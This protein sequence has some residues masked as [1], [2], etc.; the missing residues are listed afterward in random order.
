MFKILAMKQKDQRENGI[1]LVS[2][3]TSDV[4][5][6]VIEQNECARFEIFGFLVV[7]IQQN[8]WCIVDIGVTK[9]GNKWL[10]HSRYTAIGAEANLKRS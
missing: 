8:I 4:D 10:C 7:H 5:R 3:W 6:R 1:F 2:G 9:Q